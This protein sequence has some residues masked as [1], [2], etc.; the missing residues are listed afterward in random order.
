MRTISI[1]EIEGTERDVKFTGGNSL[2]LL[3]KEDG[4]GYAFMKTIIPKGGPHHWHYKNHKETCYCIYGTGVLT[5][6][7][8]KEQHYIEPGTMYILDEHE[9]HTFEALQ[10]LALISVFTPALVGDETHDENGV[11]G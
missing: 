11:Y 8:T 4:L 5:N 9:D 10:D 6:L 7:K 1:K 3:I 2:R